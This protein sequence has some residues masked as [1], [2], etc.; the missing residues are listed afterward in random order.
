MPSWLQ[1]AKPL[2]RMPTDWGSLKNEAAP[3]KE[4]RAIAAW[5]AH[6]IEASFLRPIVPL[7]QSPSIRRRVKGTWYL[8]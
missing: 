8:Q 1:F 7:E 6:A 5:N 2:P 3:S 4:R